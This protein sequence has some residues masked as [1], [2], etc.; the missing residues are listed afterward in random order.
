MKLWQIPTT[1]LKH[2]F[3]NTEDRNWLKILKSRFIPVGYDIDNVGEGIKFPGLY[4]DNEDYGKFYYQYFSRDKV[5]CAPRGNINKYGYVVMGLNPGRPMKVKYFMSQCGF[6]VIAQIH[7]IGC[8]RQL[9]YTLILL[10]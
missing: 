5:F 9:V 4:G 3:N 10:T 6:L 2:Y 7:C 8:F 1:G